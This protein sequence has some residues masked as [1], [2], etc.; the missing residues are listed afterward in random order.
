[1]P[2]WWHARDRGRA[3]TALA[4]PAVCLLIV[5]SRCHRQSPLVVAANRDELYE[6]PAVPMTVL[7]PAAPRILGGRDDM[8]GGTW[9][10]VNDAGVFAGLTNRPTTEGR[11]P[12]RRSRGEL[13]LS[14]A[15]HGS[16]AEA[17][18][19]LTAHVDPSSYNPAWLFVA[20]RRSLFAVEVAGGPRPVA[21]P[22]GPGVH[23]LENRPLGAPSAKVD[24]VRTLIDDVEELPL[25]MLERRLQVVLADHEL[26]T[27]A[28]LSSGAESADPR[29]PPATEAACVHTDHYGTRWSAVISM[30]ELGAPPRFSYT[31]G[32]PC[33]TTS[34]DAGVL[35]Q[36]E[37]AGT[38]PCLP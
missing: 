21:E 24:R 18:A 20:D 5:L 38:H 2:R 3:T 37:G 14:A 13:P 10:A 7:Q 11:D 19:W 1:M 29:R 35:W 4:S 36:R 6:R 17:V 33:T 34:E 23:V 30:P 25:R 16:A 9:L 28:P 12:T 26:P 8:A 32:P 27:A 22:L 31:P 15:R